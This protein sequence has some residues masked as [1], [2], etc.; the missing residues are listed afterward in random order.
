MFNFYIIRPIYKQSVH[1]ASYFWNF[2]EKSSWACLYDQRMIFGVSKIATNK[3]RVSLAESTFT[4]T[5]GFSE[6]GIRVVGLNKLSTAWDVLDS[7]SKTLVSGK[8]TNVGGKSLKH[9]E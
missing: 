5:I 9:W 4:F 8:T 2:E 7:W 6:D 1:K 3:F